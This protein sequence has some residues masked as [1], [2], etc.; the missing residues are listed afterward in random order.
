MVFNNKTKE[1]FPVISRSE[2][3]KLPKEKRFVK[4]S[5]TEDERATE[6]HSKLITIDMHTHI[7]TPY[8]YSPPYAPPPYVTADL[9]P[10]IREMIDGIRQSGLTCVLEMLVPNESY[11]HEDYYKVMENLGQTDAIV[12]KY[13][14]TFTRA[15][16]A[17]DIR[18]AKKEG[19]TA[20]VP[21][22]ETSALGK[23]PVERVDTF[24]GLGVRSQGL[25][26]DWPNYLVEHSGLTEF[27]GEVVAEMNKLG[28]IA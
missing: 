27:G 19:K 23:G 2:Y 3:L 21:C 13:R 1:R 15:F 17:E 20:V 10:P 18:R 22:L 24:Y 8:T 26:Y 7:F 16:G 6:L 5:R 25:C 14:D 12:D 9:F 28:M 11:Y 4:L